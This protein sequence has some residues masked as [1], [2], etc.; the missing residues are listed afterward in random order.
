MNA[1][2]VAQHMYDSLREA[3]LAVACIIPAS[4]LPYLSAISDQLF[5][6]PRRASASGLTKGFI[7]VYEA[8]SRTEEFQLMIWSQLP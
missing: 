4:E 1:A 6:H 2:Q 7:T 8:A 5:I 3:V